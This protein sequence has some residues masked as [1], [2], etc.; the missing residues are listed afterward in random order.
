MDIRETCL[1][2]S[3][4]FYTPEQNPGLSPRTPVSSLGTGY[5]WSIFFHSSIIVWKNGTFPKSGRKQ[6]KGVYAA[7]TIANKQENEEFLREKIDVFLD[8][9]QDDD[10][11][12]LRAFVSYLGN[13][14]GQVL[15]DE[16]IDQIN[17]PLKVKEGYYAPG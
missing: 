17:N 12:A 11:E 2:Y 16:D 8:L 9:I 10:R 6:L 4:L 14:F 15:T 13:M 3:R 5:Y 7:I 1:S